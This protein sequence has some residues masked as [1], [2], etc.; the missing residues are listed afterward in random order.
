MNEKLGPLKAWQWGLLAGGLGLAYYYYRKK[1][2]EGASTTEEPS[3]TFA[4]NPVGSLSTEGTGG[5]SLSGTGEAREQPTPS[6]AAPET[7]AP[8]PGIG[9][10]QLFATELGEVTQAREALQASGLIPPAQG[11]NPTLKA[12]AEKEH[13]R[14]L[15]QDKRLKALE[16][17]GRKPPGKH[18]ARKPATHAKQGSHHHAARHGKK[19]TPVAG[20]GGG[21]GSLVPHTG[22]DYVGIHHSAHKRRRPRRR[23]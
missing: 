12:H 22:G 16:R 15:A 11:A 10:G 8:A 6:T 20:G 7:G 18:N 19:K 9:A 2:E 21:G 17:Q 23:R 13:A 5:G 3:A 4:T 14:I 1:K